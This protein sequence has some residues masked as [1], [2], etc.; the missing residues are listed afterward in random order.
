[1]SRTIRLALVAVAVTAAVAPLSAASA[2][3]QGPVCKL[4]W[5]EYPDLD[6]SDG[7]VSPGRASWV[8]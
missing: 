1:M 8:C 7:T 4:Y 3:P 5:H 6:P 2:E